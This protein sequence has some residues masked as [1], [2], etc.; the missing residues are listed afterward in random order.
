MRLKPTSSKSSAT[1]AHPQKIRLLPADFLGQRLCNLFP[2]G[3]QFIYAPQP[4]DGQ[5][6]EWQTETRYPLEPR[7]LWK[8]WQ[9]PDQLIGVRFGK[10]TCYGMVDIDI[11]S[12]YHP[13]QNPDRF[14]QILSILES[15]GL[16]R[17]LILRSSHS[18]GLHLYFP[19]EQSVPSYGLALALKYAFED[20]SLHIA[21]GQL[22]LFPNPK[23]Y[24]KNGFTN[25]NGHR[26]PLQPNS[27]SCLLNRQG[28]PISDNLE[29]F[30]NIWELAANGNDLEQLQQAIADAQQRA[31]TN[32]RSGQSHKAQQWQQDDLTLIQ[33]GWTGPNQTN[34]ILKA[35]ARYGVVWEALSQEALIQ[36]IIQTA[37]TAPGYQTYCNHQHEIKQRAQ[38]WA[39]EAEQ[40]YSPYCSYPK[41]SRNIHQHQSSLDRADQQNN[42]VPFNQALAQDAQARI[43]Q[44][45]AQLEQTQQLPQGTEARAKLLTNRIKCSRRTLYKY[46]QLWHPKHYHSKPDGTAEPAT[47]S[48]PSPL[49]SEPLPKAPEPA[50]TETAEQSVPTPSLRR[51]GLQE[52]SQSGQ[53]F[54]LS[55]VSSRRLPSTDCHSHIELDDPLLSLQAK[56]SG[57]LKLEGTGRTGFPQPPLFPENLP[58]DQVGKPPG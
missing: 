10:Q 30:L 53:T 24:K 49:P 23:V 12:P 34:E 3:W 36:Y 6:P 44:A 27:G 15:I 18:G 2:H 8:Q 41:R 42:I 52:M 39:Q 37:I 48:A 26:L 40:Y 28:E 19:L 25:Y 13:N 1:S 31:K 57:D 21:P 33:Q 22:E 7:N 4:P 29:H 58:F 43:R 16:S 55:P 56:D 9:D 17:I 11:A 45:I 35:I 38:E 5:K 46:P 14:D 51:W 20:Q 32:Y 47:V 50:A 54:Y